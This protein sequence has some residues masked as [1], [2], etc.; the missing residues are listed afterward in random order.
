MKWTNRFRSHLY[1]I[2]DEFWKEIKVKENSTIHPLHVAWETIKGNPEAGSF[3]AY[4][5]L[6]YSAV[7]YLTKDLVQAVAT[8]DPLKASLFLPAIALLTYYS[9]GLIYT[10]AGLLEKK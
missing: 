3:I 8:Q 4:N 7:H 10:S 2:R 1:E 9:L 6:I 5:F